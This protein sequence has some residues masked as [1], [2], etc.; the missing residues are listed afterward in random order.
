MKKAMPWGPGQIVEKFGVSGKG[1][2]IIKAASAL[3]Y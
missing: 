1:G 3:L 2:K